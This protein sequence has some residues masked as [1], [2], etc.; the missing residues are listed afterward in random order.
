M[1]FTKNM[2][3]MFEVNFYIFKINDLQLNSIEIESN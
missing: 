1:D 3:L 2:P